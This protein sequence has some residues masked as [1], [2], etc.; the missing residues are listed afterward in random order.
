MLAAREP[1]AFVD[2]AMPQETTLIAMH[3]S[4]TPD[5]MH[6]PLLAARGHAAS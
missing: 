2:P 5:E 4:L 1:V 3:G 6:V